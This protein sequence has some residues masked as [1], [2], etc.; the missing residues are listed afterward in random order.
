MSYKPRGGYAL[1]QGQR[2]RVRQKKEMAECMDALSA[3]FSYLLP[4]PREG[5]CY[6]LLEGH[7]GFIITKLLQMFGDLETTMG[8]LNNVGLTVTPQSYLGR[9]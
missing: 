8:G 6:P 1:T 9:L 2:E 4:V 3:A 5:L 7:L